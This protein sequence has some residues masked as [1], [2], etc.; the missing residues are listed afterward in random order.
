MV[1]LREV[2]MVKA[3]VGLDR[4]HVNLL[5]HARTRGAKVILGLPLGV[6]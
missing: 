2:Q 1:D 4:Y 5:E 6:N 3:I